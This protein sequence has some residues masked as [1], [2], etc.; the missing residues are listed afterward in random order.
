M[1]SDVSNPI[2]F[3]VN[4]LPLF[5]N[6]Q[7]V[8]KNKIKATKHFVILEPKSDCIFSRRKYDTPLWIFLA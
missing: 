4:E 8:S 3:F 6:G 1:T 2:R 5:E 7:G